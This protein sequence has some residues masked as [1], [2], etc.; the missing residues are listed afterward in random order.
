MQTTP[1][2]SRPGTP[3]FAAFALSLAMLLPH[4][5]FADQVEMQ[6]GDRYNGK[7][8]SMTNDLMVVQSEVLGTIIFPRAKVAKISLGNGAPAP[9]V[10]HATAATPAKSASTNSTADALAALRQPGA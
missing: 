2:L 7:V 4:R 8:I 5:L 6:H 9:V 3:I 10:P 1:K